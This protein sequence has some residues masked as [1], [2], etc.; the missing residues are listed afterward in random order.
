[1]R[2]LIRNFLPGSF[3]IPPGACGN[4][5]ENRGYWILP[6][7]GNRHVQNCALSLADLRDPAPARASCPMRVRFVTH[8]KLNPALRFAK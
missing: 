1:V 5:R 4:A 8:K 7:P 2:Y 3:E 6:M